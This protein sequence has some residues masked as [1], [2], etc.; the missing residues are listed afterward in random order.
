MTKNKNCKV[1]E[2]VTCSNCG[3]NIVTK[4]YNK[5]FCPTEETPKKNVHK[6]YNRN[7]PHYIIGCTTCGHF[8]INTPTND[9]T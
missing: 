5:M 3:H 7:I 8:M 4:G 1:P 6:T 9:Q 2:V